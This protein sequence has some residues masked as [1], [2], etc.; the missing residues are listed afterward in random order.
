MT[1]QTRGFTLIEL[2]LS[3]AIL[4]VVTTM[5][6]AIVVAGVFL[7]R[8]SQAVA[9]ADDTARLAA[10]SIAGA[11]RSSGLYAPGGLYTWSGSATPTQIYPV[12]GLDG[13]TG[14][15]TG[16]GTGVVKTVDGSDDLW[17]VV[18]DPNS[19]RQSCQVAGSQVAL[20]AAT[21]TAN[22]VLTVQ[23]TAAMAP[24]P[25]GIFNVGDLLVASNGK[26][27][28]MMTTTAFSTAGN[29]ATITF[30]ESVHGSAFSD[31]PP[32]SGVGFQKGDVIYRATAI[33]YFIMPNPN[34]PA[35][36]TN[37]KGLYM[38]VGT[39]LTDTAGDA[40]TG[41]TG[42]GRPFSDPA[43]PPVLVDNFVEDLQLA[44]GF[45]TTG[46]G[47]PSTY[48]WQYGCP[49][50]YAN[51]PNTS[52]TTGA[53]APG[54]VPGSL[55][56]VRISVVS[57]SYQTQRDT[58]GNAIAKDSFLMPQTVEN[59][60]YGAAP[61]SPAVTTDGYWRTVYTKRVELPNVAIGN[62]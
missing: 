12:F 53:G 18:P 35:P 7:S 59:H 30:A 37:R 6:G 57:T 56:S 14:N 34:L 27:G 60:C 54:A 31:S 8:N 36:N 2:M 3:V 5:A 44:F 48:F 61:C 62:L 17:V 26:T 32:P 9:D 22:P 52:S 15:G 41:G 19:L 1:T 10:E 11:I 43:T 24:S 20:L 25:P 38:Q 46:N 49:P 47:D 45:D 21:P 42:T 23:C 4:A 50:E 29:W 40:L 13:T 55:R 16:S 58:S 28:A 51:G 33:H 39:I